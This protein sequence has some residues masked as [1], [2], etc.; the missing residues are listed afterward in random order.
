V[1]TLHGGSIEICG[2]QPPGS[3]ET[4]IGRLGARNPKLATI[5]EIQAAATAGWAG[6]P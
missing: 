4:I 6:E 2:A 1:I 3:I 5:A